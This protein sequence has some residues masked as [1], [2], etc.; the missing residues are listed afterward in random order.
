MN[1]LFHGARPL[2]LLT[3]LACTLA[4][5]EV[6]AS[7]L[8]ESAIPT[9]SAP[10]DR[11]PDAAATNS[12]TANPVS[13]TNTLSSN[14]LSSA[15]LTPSRFERDGTRNRRSDR[16]RDRSDSAAS[17]DSSGASTNSPA[18]GTDFASFGIIPDRNIFNVNRSSRSSRATR[19]APTKTIQVDTFALV[20]AMSYAKGDFAFFDG[21]NS[22]FRK[23]LKP[24]D[25]IGGFR[26]K[27]IGLN[28]VQL[29][30]AGKSLELAIG[31]HF[32]REEQGEWR[33]V[34]ETA[35][36]SASSSSSGRE[37]SASDASGGTS[38]QG[39][40]KTASADS[41]GDANDILQRLMK[42]REQEMGK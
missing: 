5:A 10:T 24:G 1:V 41:G 9:Q 21:S 32:R 42:K 27:S 7:S 8:P 18:V 35:P 16:R 40:T 23:V 20:G 31:S 25:S 6:P 39:E 29:D 30:D 26:L 3:L 15:A 2:A 13:E 19:E 36:P 11:V 17:E 33:L 38:G 28:S 4:G 12:P 37:R 34:A 14:T 22:D